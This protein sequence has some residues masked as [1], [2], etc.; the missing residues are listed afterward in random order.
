[1]TE[2]F[3]RSTWFALGCALALIWGTLATPGAR[4]EG[5]TALPEPKPLVPGAK[6]VPLWPKGSPALRAL[7]G[8]DKPEI[9]NVAKDRPGRVQSVTNIHNPS[10]EVHLAPPDKANGL[11]VIVVPGG[12]NRT[13]VVGSEGT[14]IAEW[15]NGLGIHAFIER[16]RLK[17]YDSTKDAVADTK[18]A[19]RVIRAHAKEWGVDPKRVGIMGFSAG[20]E[21]AAWVTLGFDD[22]DPKATD[23]VER[24]SCRPDFSVL[25]YPGWAHMDLTAV[26][27]NAPPT[28]LTSAGLDDAFHA[29]QSVEFYNALFQ[30]KIPVELH[31]Y[32]R[33][34][35]G[36]GISSRKG[37]PFGTWPVRFVEWAKDL[38]LMEAKAGR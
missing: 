10:I 9:F 15:L 32:R 2:A 28:F 31:I 19:F 24:E 33:G 18:R 16:Y 35:H 12:G 17:P 27:K 30:A 23:P 20:G 11:A 6:V 36:G 4:A 34:G 7:E 21:Q 1:M 38:G 13:C 22:G 26:P 37:I 3:R 5:P 25:I 29:R 14:D 8:S